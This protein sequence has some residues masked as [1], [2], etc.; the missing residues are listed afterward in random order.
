MKAF[1]KLN[2]DRVASRYTE[3]ALFRAPHKPLLLLSILEL[4][5]SK[6]I[7]ENRI[8]P[9]SD[10][11]EAFWSYTS[12]VPQGRRMHLWLPFH[13]MQSESF[14][15]LIDH[16]GN[17]STQK[18]QPKSVRRLRN[19]ISH[20]RFSSAVWNRLQSPEG[21]KSAKRTILEYHFSREAM[22]ALNGQGKINLE[23]TR[24][25][26]TLSDDQG[27]PEGTEKPVRDRLFRKRI[28][29]AYQ[30][31]CAFSGLI[32]K[33]PNDHTAIDAAHIHAWSDSHNDRIQN[34][35]AISKLCHWAYD[36]GLITVTKNMQIKVSHWVRHEQHEH[37]NYLLE[38]D[39]MPFHLPENPTHHPNEQHFEWHR[40]H[41]FNKW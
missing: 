40:K 10:L 25:Y 36:A 32:L 15:E 6:V 39:G 23:T 31:R 17:V 8:E 16:E 12:K 35:M 26:D 4:I 2:V 7:T 1:E 37:V 24:L 9:S 18:S 3:H 13:H 21:V 30:H 22:N 28:Q 11:V 38:L 33:N 29:N 41:R 5:E 27:S 19:R 14:W 34:G 20:A